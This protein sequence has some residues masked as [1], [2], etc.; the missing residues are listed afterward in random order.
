M[1]TSVSLLRVIYTLTPENTQNGGAISTV[2]TIARPLFSLL[3][4]PLHIL[5]SVF[6]FI[7]SV[8]RIPVPQ[9]RFSTLNFYRPLRQR[10]SHRGGPDR[11][12]RELEEELG[13]V[14]I[15][16]LKSPRGSTSTSGVEAGPSRLTARN[17][18]S[19]DLL[20]EGKKL[21]PDFI[22]CGYEEFLRT[23]QREL[24]IGCVILVT[25][26]HD[27]TAEFKR[28]E[29]T[30]KQTHTRAYIKFNSEQH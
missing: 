27:D 5:S 8:L 20:S 4:F 6:R 26:E 29:T 3:A 17:V 7:F 25:E 14:S 28:Y 23:C 9:F 21:L 10:P 16:R 18:Q 12:V 15:G 13:A 24:K 11:W 2:Y 30:F 22:I 19:D 1:G